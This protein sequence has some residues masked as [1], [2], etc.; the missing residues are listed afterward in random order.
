MAAYFVVDLDIHHGPCGI[1][2]GGSWG[3]QRPSLAAYVMLTGP[4]DGAIA[5]GWC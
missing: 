5:T 1:G 3:G 2:S 4:T